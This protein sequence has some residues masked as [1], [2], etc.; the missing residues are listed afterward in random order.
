MEESSKKNAEQ[1][2]C[3]HERRTKFLHAFYCRQV[4]CGT[5]AASCAVLKESNLTTR[6]ILSHRIL[7]N[8]LYELRKKERKSSEELARK[9]KKPKNELEAADET[10]AR[11]KRAERGTRRF[12]T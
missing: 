3:P 9:N 6:K 5:K 2:E 12:E 8:K 7:D 4:S 11:V 10:A 1:R